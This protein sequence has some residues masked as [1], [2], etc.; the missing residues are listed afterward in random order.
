M[1]LRTLSVLVF[2]G[3]NKEQ[4]FQESVMASPRF[5]IHQCKARDLKWKSALPLFHV[6]SPN[7]TSA[8]AQMKIEVLNVSASLKLREKLTNFFPWWMMSPFYLRKHKSTATGVKYSEYLHRFS[9]CVTMCS[10]STLTIST[11]FLKVG[12]SSPLS[13]AF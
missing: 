3:I 10:C 2:S 1:E 9:V 6:R 12:R 5:Q 13:G 8:A 4:R 11:A 7:G